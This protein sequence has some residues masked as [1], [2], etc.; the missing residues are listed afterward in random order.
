MILKKM[1]TLGLATSVA[2]AASS[3]TSANLP[4]RPEVPI[5]PGF[6]LAE[7]VETYREAQKEL[8]QERRDLA[9]ALRD[10]TVEERRQAIEDYQAA[11]ADR[12]AL[13]K[14]LAEQIRDLARNSQSEIERPVVNRPE[15]AE[16]ERP[17]LTEGVQ[18]LISEF[19]LVREAL[20]QERLAVLANLREA[21]DEDRASAL[22]VLRQQ[23]FELA[24]QQRQM[25]QEIRDAVQETREGRRNK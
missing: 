7:I 2:L 13:H 25:A 12:I 16:G 6:D 8:V 21:T 1:T 15:I 19:R 10:Q 23:N 4:D 18:D 20:I 5:L 22:A 3:F 11:N 17:E 14:A 24:A 9:E